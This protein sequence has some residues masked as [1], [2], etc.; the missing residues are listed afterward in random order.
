MTANPCGRHV[1]KLVV[2][3]HVNYTAPLAALFA[4]LRA[5][6][7]SSL[8]DVLV[9]Q[10]GHAVDRP[11]QRER[12][13]AL[14]REAAERAEAVVSIRASANAIDYTGLAALYRH[15][16]HPLVRAEMYVYVHDTVRF[17]A[18]FVGRFESFR[19]PSSA[20]LFTTWPLPNSNICAFGAAVLHK[21]GSNFDGELS[22]AEAFPMEFGY[23]GGRAVGAA[24]RPL[25][26]FGHVVRLGPRLP[27]GTADVYA[28]GSAR[29]RFYYPA[30]GLVKFSMESS[31]AGD[32]ARG[33]N[34]PLFGGAR[35][36]PHERLGRDAQPVRATF[37]PPPPCWANCASLRV[38]VPRSRP[39]LLADCRRRREGAEGGRGEGAAV[40]A[41]LGPVCFCKT[42]F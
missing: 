41:G 39:L 33:A 17:E 11:P 5:I 21:F 27:N 24:V 6:A 4:S 16:V 42:L 25:T 19:L 18:P 1:L 34:A 30:F 31:R 38:E 20:R 26:A 35:W 29:R 3:S 2:N 12:V 40:I 37:A 8:D 10:A 23:V 13:A 14:T 32:V 28:T 9:V 22:K 7:F 15:R 36:L